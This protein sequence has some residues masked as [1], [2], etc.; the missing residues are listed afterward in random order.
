MVEKREGKMEGVGSVKG[1]SEREARKG[2]EGR[3]EVGKREVY[4]VGRA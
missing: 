4:G 1:G 3:S 2:G